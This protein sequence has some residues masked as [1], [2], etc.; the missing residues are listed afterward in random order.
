MILHKL[1]MQT[2]ICGAKQL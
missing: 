2:W 1:S